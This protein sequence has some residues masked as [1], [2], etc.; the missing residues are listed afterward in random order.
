MVAGNFSGDARWS[1]EG[2]VTSAREFVSYV[3]AVTPA[4]NGELK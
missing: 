4:I 1:E 3:V 2:E